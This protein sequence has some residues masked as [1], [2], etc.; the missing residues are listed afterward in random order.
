VTV[1]TV[2]RAVLFEDLPLKD[3]EDLVVVERHMG[4]EAT[5]MHSPA[6]LLDLRERKDLFSA[7]SAS[8]GF[9]SLMTGTLVP[10]Y[11]KGASV[12][13]DYFETLG[14]APILGQ[15]FREWDDR[16]DVVVLSW[17]LW[18]TQLAGDPAIQGKTIMLDDQAYR[19]VGVM[20]KSL[21]FL[22]A[23]LWVPGPQ[24]LPRPPF[25]AGPELKVRRDLAYLTILGRLRSGW[26][27]VTVRVAVKAAGR[28]IVEKYPANLGEVQF[29]IRSLKELVVGDA[30][31]QLMILSACVALVFV[32]VCLSL[33]GLLVGR[34]ISRS[35]QDAVRLAL[36]ARGGQVVVAGLADSLVL[37]MAGGILGT[38]AS[39]RGVHLFVAFAPPMQRSE[40][41]SLDAHERWSDG[42]RQGDK[43]TVPL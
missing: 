23:N 40:E 6:D 36:G 43:W 10:I 30:H 2:A 34:G 37:T 19:V 14:A 28:S 42:L 9:R 22:E 1:Y 39:I 41:I 11:V 25:P 17:Q 35:H 18:Q 7:V 21:A 31:N 3:P 5:L 29:S 15:T 8:A 4:D 16:T 20:P 13:P 38:L 32:L 33:A 12:T 24:G 27:P 26:N